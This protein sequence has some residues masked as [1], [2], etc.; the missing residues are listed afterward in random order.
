M[1]FLIEGGYIQF[2]IC[3]LIIALAAYLATKYNNESDDK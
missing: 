1:K 2:G 3:I